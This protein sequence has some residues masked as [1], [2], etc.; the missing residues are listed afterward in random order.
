MIAP[1]FIILVLIPA[2][3]GRGKKY[4]ITWITDSA[5]KS[6]GI[7]WIFHCEDFLMCPVGQCNEFILRFTERDDCPDPFHAGDELIERLP[8][9]Q[10]AGNPDY[11]RLERF[12]CKGCSHIIGSFGVIVIIGPAY[13]PEILHPVRYAAEGGKRLYDSFIRRPVHF[14]SD[15]RSQY[16]FM[17]M[18]AQKLH[19]VHMDERPALAGDHPLFY[20][21][22]CFTF[23]RE[24]LDIDGMVELI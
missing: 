21:G 22:R 24:E 4:S 6:D 23:N 5:S 10:S 2:C 20:A 15:Y 1:R 14:C 8:P 17:V 13:A 12:Q 11:R 16:V 19:I 18:P 7:V 9:V 3:A